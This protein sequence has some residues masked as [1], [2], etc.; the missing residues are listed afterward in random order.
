MTFVYIFFLRFVDTELHGLCSRFGA[1]NS[2][3]ILLENPV[4]KNVLTVDRFTEEVSEYQNLNL[5][6]CERIKFR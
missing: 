2:S 6:N 1:P 4:G 5:I 3:T